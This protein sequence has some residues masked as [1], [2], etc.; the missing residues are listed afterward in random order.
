MSNDKNISLADQLKKDK[1]VF[2][3]KDI[4]KDAEIGDTPNPLEIDL[5]KIQSRKDAENALRLVLRAAKNNKDQEE[6]KRLNDLHH[7]LFD[8]A[9]VLK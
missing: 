5:T 4:P 9:C 6:N 2:E 3:Y 1:K 8:L 7:K